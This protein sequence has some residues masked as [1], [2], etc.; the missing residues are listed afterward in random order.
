MKDCA[1]SRSQFGSFIIDTRGTILGFDQAM[2]DLTNWPAIDVV[3]HSKDLNLSNRPGD[4]GKSPIR[5]T[6]LYEGHIPMQPGDANRELT[7]NCADGR[8][9]D[10]ET[11]LRPLE[12]PG[13][14][15]LVTVLD[16][17]ASSARESAFSGTERCDT[18]T[19]LPDRAAFAG[20][21]AD[22]LRAAAATARP[23]ALILLDVDH[24]RETNDRLGHDAGDAVLR[25]LAG[26][27][28]VSIEDECRL[29]RLGND[30]FA[31]L[32]RDAGR[33][34]ARQAAAALRS[35][36]ERFR[37]FADD[38]N[39]DRRPITITLGAAS[40]PA[41]ADSADELVERAQEALDEARS[42][43]RNRVWCYLRRPRVPIQVPV[44]FDGADSP[45]VGYSRD[46][47]PSGIFVQTTAGIDV[48][49][50]CAL[51][52]PL[53]GHDGKVHV[54]G[55]VVRTVH[56]ETS[57][58]TRDVRVPGLGLEFERFGGASDRRAIDSF[59]HENE[60]ESLRPEDGLLSL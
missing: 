52:F 4:R 7:L 30:D 16:V 33:G 29:A 12:G 2:E 26:I 46:L 27:L 24:L 34:E 56:P 10:V 31:V 6:P 40:F 45:L 15:L 41:D 50:R 3:G 11:R 55:R 42:M 1:R 8:R 51:A 38:F 9:L 18:L 28:R 57:E 17:L 19:G 49:M 36:V 37:F 25:K 53:P 13:E 48:G 44:F 59:L 21:L 58:E 39:G 35:T 14:R 54:V 47:S 5:T 60:A 43:G 22:D 20:Q 23:L 32:L